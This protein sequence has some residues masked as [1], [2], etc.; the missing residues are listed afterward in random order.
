MS[1]VVEFILPWN[2]TKGRK[3]QIKYTRKI[4]KKEELIRQ[5]FVYK[6][7]PTRPPLRLQVINS[8]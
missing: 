2:K 1:T 3:N 8:N 7:L 5:K 6:S 4:K